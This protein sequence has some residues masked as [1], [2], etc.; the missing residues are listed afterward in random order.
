[1]RRCA[2][3]LAVVLGLGS[4]AFAQRTVAPTTAVSGVLRFDANA[5]L[6]RFSGTSSALTGALIGGPA[7]EEVRGWVELPVD[8]LRTGNGTRDRDMRKS[9]EA[10]RFPTIRF[11]LDELRPSPMQGDS[12]VATLA[13]RF[14]IHGVSRS[15]AVPA[16]ITWVPEGI[17]L[18]ASISM[19]V[20]DYRVGGLSR[21]LGTL[22]MQP[23]IVVHINLLFAQPRP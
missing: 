4:P 13:G 5:T 7:L 14:T 22:R 12:M 9:L 3:V 8:S 6:G 11:D 23:D 1:M 10:A 16:Q 17:R 2:G 19:D 20:R 18:E 21:M 15:V